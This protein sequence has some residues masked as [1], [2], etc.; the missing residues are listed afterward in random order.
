MQIS[1]IIPAYNEEKNI[2]RTLKKYNKF[3]K[4]RFKK[5]YEIII[6]P[7]NCSDNTFKIVK[8]FA[9]NKKQI[10]IFNFPY[11]IGKGRAVME[12]FNIAKGDYI[13]FVDADISTNPE[14][15]YKLYKNINNLDGII[16]SRRIKGSLIIPKR[17][18]NKKKTSYLFNKVVNLLFNLGFKDTQCGAKLFKKKTINFLLQNY[19]ETGWIFDVDLLYLCKKNNLKI[20]EY[21][22]SWRE[23]KT[24][25]LT[26]KDGIF[27]V[28]KLFKYRIKSLKS[29]S[30]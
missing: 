6:V 10:R 13:G 18:L 15:F 22:I 1:L 4:K 20:L 5:N 12:G 7:N 16:A 11:Y 8:N 21:P 24:S 23:L 19:T 28:L 17:K 25:K 14:N 29:P 3:F 27:S 30:S 26:F 9:K 2:L